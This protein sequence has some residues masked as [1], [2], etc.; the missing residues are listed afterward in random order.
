MV[1]LSPE[2]LKFSEK[3]DRNGTNAIIPDCM[4]L[5]AFVL[6]IGGFYSDGGLEACGK[7]GAIGKLNLDVRAIMA[8][9]K[10]G[11]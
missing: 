10:D 9:L 8:V 7:P 2:R 11:E 1:L 6:R 3:L 5:S 4:R